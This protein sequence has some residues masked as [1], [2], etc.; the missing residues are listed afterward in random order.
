MREKPFQPSGISRFN[1]LI[2]VK[3]KDAE[4]GEAGD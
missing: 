1:L 4:A 3:M 2:S